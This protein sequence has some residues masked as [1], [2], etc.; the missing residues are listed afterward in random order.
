MTASPK[1]RRRV[2]VGV[3]TV[4]ALSLGVGVAAGSRITSPE[5]AA[6]KTAPPK[7]SQIT[8]PVEKKA[9]ASKVVARG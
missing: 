8:V 4:A 6:A 9:L 1:S 5:D 2:L 7:A 3:S